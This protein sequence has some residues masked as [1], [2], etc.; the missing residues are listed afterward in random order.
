MSRVTQNRGEHTLEVERDGSKG[1]EDQT[2][3]GVRGER[4]LSW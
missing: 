4:A 2:Y 3:G 1:R